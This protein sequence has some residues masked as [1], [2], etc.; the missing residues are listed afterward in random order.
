[1]ADLI[2]KTLLDAVCTDRW[3][4]Q[5]DGCHAR[6]DWQP[7]LQ[8]F[9]SSSAGVQL[10]SFL[11]AR[12]AA[13][14]AIY[15]PEP[16]RALQLTALSDVRVVILGQDPYHGSGQAQGLAFS[17]AGGVKIPPSLRNIFKEIAR[18]V[19]QMPPAHGSL[20]SWA[21]QGVLLLNTCL[22]V[23]A[24]QPASHAKRGWEL[25]TDSLIEACAAKSARVVFMLWGAHAQAKRSLIAQ[26]N[27][28][29]RHLILTANHPSPLSALRAPAPFI[30]CGH[31][32]QARRWLGD[33]RLF[34]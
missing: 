30:G 6:A 27:A 17:V 11:Q 3:Q 13:Q 23:E 5:L 22:T 16:L 29:A 34:L 10:Q 28:D 1:M 12:L 8:A 4:G 31:F 15:P 9:L 14:A 25:L 24:G 32:G 20:Q 26:H 21:A 18:D 2:Q 7:L 33:A 19:Q